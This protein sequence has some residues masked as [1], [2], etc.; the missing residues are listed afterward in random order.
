MIN[1]E[2]SR[3]Y[4][5][6]TASLR[7]WCVLRTGGRFLCGDFRG[8]SKCPGWEAALADIQVRQ[9]SERVINPEVLR[10]LEGNSPR[11]LDLVGRRLPV[12][13]RPFGRLFAGVPGSLMYRELERGRLSYR[14]YCFTKDAA[15]QQ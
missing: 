6:L 14:M 8:R 5:R 3:A 7:K 2:A 11:S 12:Y 13:M 15:A 1:V 10:G 4:P 9:V